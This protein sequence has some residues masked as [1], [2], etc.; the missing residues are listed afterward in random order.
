MPVESIRHRWLKDIVIKAEL[1]RKQM[2]VKQ[3]KKF[4]IIDFDETRK[5][6][7]CLKIENLGKRLQK[8]LER[9]PENV[10]SKLVEDSDHFFKEMIE[11][12]DK[13]CPQNYDDETGESD[14]TN[15]SEDTECWNE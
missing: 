2:W 7:T 3:K 6:S 13:K 10:I 4:I 1:R 15:E 8:F 9:T 12:I 5:N 14:I 11:N